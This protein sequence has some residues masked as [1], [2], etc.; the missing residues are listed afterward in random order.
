MLIGAPL[1]TPCPQA[2]F[3]QDE[4]AKTDTKKELAA[5]LGV[6]L[7]QVRKEGSGTRAHSWQMGG[8]GAQ[9][10]GAC[11]CEVMPAHQ[12]LPV[13]RAPRRICSPAPPLATP[14]ALNRTPTALPAGEQVV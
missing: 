12:S 9:L 2:L 14:T 4:Y 10:R 6:E 11:S 5:D 13:A 8:G 1:S 3:A 7:A